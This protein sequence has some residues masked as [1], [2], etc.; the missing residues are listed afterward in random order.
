MKAAIASVIAT[1]T[2]TGAFAQVAP[3]HFGEPKGMVQSRWD[4]TREIAA[5]VVKVDEAGAANLAGKRVADLPKKLPPSMQGALGRCIDRRRASLTLNSVE[6]RGVLAEYLMVAEPMRMRTAALRVRA[7]A[8]VS[9][10][11][12]DNGTVQEL[13]VDCAVAAEPKAASALIAT[14][15]GSAEERTAI[16][17]LAG[18]LQGCAPAEGAVHFTPALLRA[19]VA[20]ALYR[21]VAAPAA[22]V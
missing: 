6:L 1:T 7:P 17:P 9:P 5:C 20:A 3:G 10:L 16:A 15:A 21:Q 22:G 4:A 14:P 13:L 18:A 8:R 11:G 12:V 2:V 19:H